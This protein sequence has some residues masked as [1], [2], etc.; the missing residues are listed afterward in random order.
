MPGVARWPLPE[1]LRELDHLPGASRHPVTLEYVL[2]EGVNDSPQDAAALGRL[3]AGRPWQV[4]LIGLNPVEGSPMRSPG[5]A[6]VQEFARVLRAAGVKAMVRK[7]RGADIEAACGQ[8]R[9][10]G[11]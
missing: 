4:N 9:A 11:G 6:A 2:V 3:M 1:L 8:L 5:E 10:G 7:S